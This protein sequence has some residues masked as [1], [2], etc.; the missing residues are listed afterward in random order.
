MQW[1]FESIR[2]LSQYHYIVAILI[3]FAAGLITSF[4]PCMLGMA[5][6]IATFQYKVHKKMQRFV[7][8]A[9]IFSFAVTLT[10]LGLVSSYFGDRMLM[11]NQQFGHILYSFVSIVFFALG[12][13]I[14][15]FRI[16]HLFKLLPI[17]FIVFYS[18]QK[19]AR[20]LSPVHPVVKAYSLGTLFGLTPSPCTTPMVLAMLAYSTITGSVLL[21]G[22][23][24][25]VYGIGHGIPFFIISW[26]TGTFKRSKRMIRWQRIFNKGLGFSLIL[27]GLY[28]FFLYKNPPMSSM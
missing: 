11:W 3:S 4:N 12:F 27:I 9:F 26:L 16:H 21:G 19:N 6:S 20:H 13:Y 2:Q 14:L 5:S 15:G 25:F 18:K 22:L 1:A 24:L 8:F 28:F 7:R 17:Q 23:L 10:F